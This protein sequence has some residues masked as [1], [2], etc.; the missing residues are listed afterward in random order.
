M[1]FSHMLSVF[2][3]RCNR[4]FPCFCP[5]FHVA[6]SR[7]AA[8]PSYQPLTWSWKRKSCEIPK[9][10][11]KK[12]SVDWL[13]NPWCWPE[14]CWGGGS[15]QMGFGYNRICMEFVPRVFFGGKWKI[16][17]CFLLCLTWGWHCRCSRKGQV[18]VCA[19]GWLA[20]FQCG[21]SNCWD[22]VSKKTHHRQWYCSLEMVS[23]EKLEI[24]SIYVQNDS[25]R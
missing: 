25:S 11:W 1:L 8:I 20:P 18:Y 7:V 13:V 2:P 9:R 22:R 17:H 16:L 3:L 6:R 21:K 15:L 24:C 14:R 19:W 10:R 12:S 5:P 23:L 4:V